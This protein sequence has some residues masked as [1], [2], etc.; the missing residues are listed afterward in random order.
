MVSVLDVVDPDNAAEVA[1]R[2]ARVELPRRAQPRFARQNRWYT[3]QTSESPP[4]SV[5]RNVL[6]GGLRWTNRTGWKPKAPVTASWLNTRSPT[7]IVSIGRGPLMVSTG[8]PAAKQVR[9]N[10]GKYCG[11]TTWVTSAW[12]RCLK[13]EAELVEP[14][15]V[16]GLLVVAEATVRQRWTRGPG[17]Y[18]H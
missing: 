10:G 4:E 14:P 3:L 12:G 9:I 8:V 18:G 1:K 5:N 11:A 6:P 17:G 16:P 15:G 7:W 2:I 13:A